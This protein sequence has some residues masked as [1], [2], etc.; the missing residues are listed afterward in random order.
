LAAGKAGGTTI[1]IMSS[2]LNLMVPTKAQNKKIYK[3][4][5]VLK[6]MQVYI[7]VFWVVKM[8][9]FGEVINISEKPDVYNLTV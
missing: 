1:V 7:A 4:F 9:I 6:A 5:E 2:V 8:S 3:R